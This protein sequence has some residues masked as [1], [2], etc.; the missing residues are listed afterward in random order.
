MPI[1]PGHR[2][3]RDRALSA[4][5]CPGP[6]FIGL[7]ERQTGTRHYSKWGKGHRSAVAGTERDPL[8]GKWQTEKR[9]SRNRSRRSSELLQLT[10]SKSTR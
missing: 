6:E 3:R 7:Y 9:R 1:S 8:I 10:V 2:R 4:L 5:G